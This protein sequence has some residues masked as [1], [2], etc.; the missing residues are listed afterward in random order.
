MNYRKLLLLSFSA[1]TASLSCYSQD[2]RPNILWIMIEDWSTDL[3]CYGTKGVDTPNI[4]KLASQG[5]LYNHAY[6]TSPVS[7]TSRSAMMTGYYQNFIGANQH[8]RYNHYPL[9]EDIVPIP[10]LMK[11]AGYHTQLMSYKVDCNFLPEKKEE[12]FEDVR[13]WSSRKNGEP[14]FTENNKT[15]KP[16]FARI[17]FMGTHRDWQRDPLNPIS[18]KDVEL[19]PYYADTEFNRRDWA[20][21]LEQ[22][23]VVDR[24]VGELLDQL[25]SEGLAD[26]TIVFFLGD[27]GRCHFRGKQFLYEPGTKV[28][29]I[30]RYGDKVEAG[31]VKDDLVMS[32]DICATAL[33]VAGVEPKIP[34]HGKSLLGEGTTNRKYVFTARD[35]MGET[36]DSMRAIRSKDGYKL[37]LNLMP[38]RPYMQYSA[39]KESQYPM[40][41]EM[42]CLYYEGKLNKNQMKFF[43]QT[44]PI[45]ELYDLNKDPFELNNLA[46]NPKY[47]EVKERLISE[48]E[49]WRN[50]VIFDSGVSEE[51]RAERVFPKECPTVSTD[52][53][54]FENSN[55]FDYRVVGLPSWFPTRSY[56]EW[57]KIRDD[58]AKTI[59]TAP[60][61]KLVK[62]NYIISK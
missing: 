22:M 23:Q 46:D 20:N 44:K 32:I 52:R 26:N 49:N 31:Q 21:G 61:K 45:Y 6:T 55:N 57:K 34:L 59:F 24:E 27:N 1:A 54:V 13:Q 48:L 16:F 60:D 8:A 33:E 9:P 35:T 17:T 58:W 4:D 10:F 25:E 11:E 36:H 15:G 47:I 42:M 40:I 62:P 3:S 2:S 30:M 28:P 53:Y 50:N 7:S 51:F 19:P 37:I 14:F 41:A 38:E 56:E 18:T 29:F 12:L 5:I 43:A 39:Y